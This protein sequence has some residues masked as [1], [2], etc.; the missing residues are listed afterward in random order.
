[1]RGEERRG[2]ERRGEERRGLVPDPV[3]GPWSSHG[4]GGRLKEVGQRIDRSSA[5]AA[6]PRQA[7]FFERPNPR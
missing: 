3:F 4:I 2:E 5:P 1:M 6:I 7:L